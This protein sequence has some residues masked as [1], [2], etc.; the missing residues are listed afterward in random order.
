[1]KKWIQT[2]GL[3]FA[4]AFVSGCGQTQPDMPSETSVAVEDAQWRTEGLAPWGEQTA[5]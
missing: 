2:F 3:L 1:M 5:E 4:L